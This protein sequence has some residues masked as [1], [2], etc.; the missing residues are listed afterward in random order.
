MLGCLSF[1]NPN[2]YPTQTKI[3]FIMKNKLFQA[4]LATVA[5]TGIFTTANAAYAGTLSYSTSFKPNT[6]DPDYL[7]P[8]ADQ[9]YDYTD[10]IDSPLKIKKFNSKLGKLESINLEFSGK[11]IGDGGVE[12]RDNKAQA[13]TVNLSGLLQLSGPDGQNLLELVPTATLTKNVAKY[14]KKLDFGGDSGFTFEGLSANNS[15]TKTLTND[16]NLSLFTGSGRLDFLFTALAQST[17]TGSGNITSEINTYAGADLKVTYVYDEKF[18]E[19]PEPATLV[20][21]GLAFGG[22]LVSRRRQSN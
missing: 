22:M 17:V 21:L 20:G 12:S 11:I 9:G 7:S 13:L 18:A 6:S 19:V 5:V 16:S 14:D 2:L 3:I 8:Y 1:F 10:I 4:L 15:G